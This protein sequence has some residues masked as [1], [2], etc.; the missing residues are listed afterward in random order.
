MGRAVDVRSSW[1]TRLLVALPWSGCPRVPWSPA[2]QSVAIFSSLVSVAVHTAVCSV[3]AAGATDQSKER[4]IW[5][6]SMK[7][8]EQ[9]VLTVTDQWKGL[10][11]RTYTKK[12]IN[13]LYI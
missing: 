7:K 4:P 10:Y 6:I 3:M 5:P 12:V 2:V 13:Y 1:P 11:F 8:P 9:N